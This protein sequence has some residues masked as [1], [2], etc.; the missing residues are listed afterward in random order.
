MASVKVVYKTVFNR[1]NQVD[2][3][4][5]A[6]VLIEAYQSRERRYFKT[7]IR[8]LPNEW[9]TKR[10]EVK[11]QPQINRLIRDK[12]AEL[13][14]FELNFSAV[15]NRPFRL[16]DFDLLA[17]AEKAK[18][19]PSV[20]FTSFA[21]EQ[22]DRDHAA[23]TIGKVTYGRYKRVIG[24]LA[25]CLKKPA[26]DFSDI[27][28][29]LIDDFNAHFLAV[30]NKKINTVYKH[31]Q[32][33]QQYLTR[34][35][36]KGLFKV[37]D[38]P[39]NDFRPEKE[40]VE[41]EILLPA[42]IEKIEQFVFTE[43]HE[44]LGFYRDAFLLA[45]YTLLRIGDVTRIRMSNIV[46]T[47]HGLVLQLKAQKTQK[48]VRL[49]LHQLHPIQNG[50]SKPERLIKQY[51][52][53]DKRPLFARSHARLNEYVKEVVRL[54]GISKHVTFHTSR[55][56]GITFLTT[57]LPTPIVQ[58]LAQHSNIATTMGYVHISGQHITDSLDGVKW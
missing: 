10:S 17:A 6:H 5:K 3:T 55:H 50:L 43:Q 52:R 30:E 15:Y 40:P 45:Y 54:A 39:Y 35:I 21:L 14:N 42:E 13:E 31:H 46:E 22:I 26:V 44:H 24:L 48:L 58:Q 20:T 36:K 7:G 41:K 29:T 19:Q 37:M 12:M 4:G 11:K 49:P 16:K 9:D 18:L 1:R 51:A 25:D 56:S 28:Y 34:A 38:N 2:S 57:K 32:V 8:L 33:I 53:T 27:T 47:E 23:G